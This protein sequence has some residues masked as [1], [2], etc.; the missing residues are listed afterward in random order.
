MWRAKS[1][2]INHYSN[3]TFK[4][5]KVERGTLIDFKHEN[6]PNNWIDCWNERYFNNFTRL[7]SGTFIL[8]YYDIQGRGEQLRYALA[9]CG[10]NFNDKRKGIDVIKNNPLKSTYGQLPI[11]RHNDVWYSQ[12]TA[13]LQYICK[14]GKLWP[15]NLK[16]EAIAIQIVLSVED[17]RTLLTDACQAK[18]NKDMETYEQWDN[19]HKIRYLNGFKLQL[20]KDD[21]FVNDKFSGA[22]ISVYNLLNDFVLELD[23]NSLDQY[24]TLL[25]FI[26]R[27]EKNEGIKQYLS[28]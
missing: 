8:F 6:C 5:H 27:V 9:A 1:W 15:T 2:D 23:K 24:P 25:K 17:C 26:K 12:G 20:G 4:L 7:D 22:D 14:L 19:V 21:Y 3:V 28:L 10:F 18:K 16:Y 13:I 11:L